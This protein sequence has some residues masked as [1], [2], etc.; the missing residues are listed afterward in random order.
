M[1]Q[2][3]LR[4]REKLRVNTKQRASTRASSRAS[5]EFRQRTWNLT[6]CPHMIGS[7]S[8]SNSLPLV[9][10]VLSACKLWVVWH[11]SPL[12]IGWNFFFFESSSGDRFFFKSWWSHLLALMR[13]WTHRVGPELDLRSSH[14]LFFG[15]NNVLGR[16]TA[17]FFLDE[18]WLE[19]YFDKKKWNIII[20]HVPKRALQL[21]I[22]MCWK[23]QSK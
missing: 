18:S 12:E 1:A 8:C 2:N 23:L 9:R 13:P 7:S 11:W 3:I 10:T 5:S 21:W 15:G 17:L 19:T 4:R 20:D 6:S 22:F 16:S 14:T